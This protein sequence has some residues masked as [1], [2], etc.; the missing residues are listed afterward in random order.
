MHKLG[1]RCPS[2]AAR[3]EGSAGVRYAG[4]TSD[5]FIG[6]VV[7]YVVK[8]VFPLVLHDVS[9]PNGHPNKARVC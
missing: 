6:Y 3:V 5:S 7:G 1:M 4:P 8:C 9:L 2:P